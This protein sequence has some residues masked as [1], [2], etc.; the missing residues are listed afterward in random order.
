MY[1][2]DKFVLLVHIVCRLETVGS[3][4]M[5]Q[6][7]RNVNETKCVRGDYSGAYYTRV[8]VLVW[9]VQL[10]GHICV[11]VGDNKGRIVQG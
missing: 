6:N 4:F 11:C 9:C 5:W 2:K 8:C 7:S 1:H 10:T 3:G